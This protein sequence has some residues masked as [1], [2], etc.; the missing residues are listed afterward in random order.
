MP[1]V[2]GYDEFQVAP[3][4]PGAPR[5]ES[6]ASAALL[7]A[8]AADTEALGKG[9]Q[10]AGNAAGD[11]IARMQDAEN[12]DKLF[13]AETALKNDWVQFSTEQSAKRGAAASAEGGVTK[14]TA[15]WFGK[16]NERYGNLLEND[17][18]RRL[19]AQSVEKLRTQG[20]DVMSKHQATEQRVSLVESATSSI[21]TSISNAARFA[22][23]W[24]VSESEAKNIK[25]RVGVVAQLEG[26]TTERREAEE[27]KHLTTLHAQVI[28]QLAKDGGPA[29]EAYFKQFKDE[30]DGSKL[31][32]IGEFARKATATSIGDST[33][34]TIF[35]ALGPKSNTDPVELLKMEDELRK[36]LAGN[37]DAIKVGI[38][39]L[40]ERVT[41]YKDQRREQENAKMASVNTL[42]LQ[43]ASSSA[44]RRSVE[45]LQLSPDDGLKINTFL[46]NRDASRAS[47]AAAEESR[48][49]AAEQRYEMRLTREGTEARMR[50]SNPEKLMEM[51]RN[52]VINQLPL[53]GIRNTQELLEKWDAYKASSAKFNEAKIDD[54]DFKTTAM[55]F[56]MR[57]NEKDKSEREKDDLIRLRSAVENAIA[58]GQRAKNGSLTRKEKVEIMERVV[59]D[60]VIEDKFFNFTHKPDVRATRTEEE[61]K[62]SYVKVGPYAQR[63]KYGDI[64]EAWRKSTSETLR[65]LGVY[66]SE[67]ELATRWLK[68]K[69]LYKEKK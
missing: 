33:A 44:I 47:R 2:P 8:G 30:I 27:R 26:W 7:G 32:E 59:G 3:R 53:L 49:A 64:E 66:P 16:S 20:L 39:G 37:D 11:V 21:G 25:Q 50:M 46:D 60:K 12:A 61:L 43:G 13:Q 36:K 41:A 68:Y 1:R 35:K 28:Q 6:A 5:A 51:S 38:A 48:A 58:D 18:Q 69:G 56:G 31:A 10:S 24:R 63:V 14:Q 45:F 15:D 55:K 19:F 42:I 34:D 65:A 57:P 67:E 17:V 54:E 23:D 29:A 22:N 40:R 4:T 52:Q 62:N 9:M